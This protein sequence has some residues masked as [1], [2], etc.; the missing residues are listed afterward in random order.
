[1]GHIPLILTSFAFSKY[2]E[3][4]DEYI[5]FLEYLLK[6]YATRETLDIHILPYGSTDEHES[7]LEDIGK[8]NKT[9]VKRSL[10]QTNSITITKD[11]IGFYP[12][13][14]LDTPYLVRVHTTIENTRI[15]EDDGNAITVLVI[16]Y[17]LAVKN[18]D[19]SGDEE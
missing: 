2:T 5:F 12:F 4:K 14:I 8:V 19:G 17:N 3:N 7:A 16:A 18:N 10:E 15:T 6:E 11:T 1:M 13:T 9:K